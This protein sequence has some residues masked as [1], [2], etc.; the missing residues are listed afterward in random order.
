MQC[1]T[2]YYRQ[3]HAI[4]QFKSFIISN[5]VLKFILHYLL[6]K[7][8]IDV[9]MSLNDFNLNIENEENDFSFRGGTQRI[10]F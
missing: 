2:V 7:Y 10:I 4:K 5:E 8:Y 1:R 3:R 6:I 9:S